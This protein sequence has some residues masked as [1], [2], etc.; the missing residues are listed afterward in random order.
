MPA[1]ALQSEVVSKH[2]PEVVTLTPSPDMELSL[3]SDESEG[4]ESRPT[5]HP[6]GEC[7][8]YVGAYINGYGARHI[9]GKQW[10]VH[11]WSYTLAYGPIPRGLVIDHLCRNRKCMRPSH[12]EAV[13]NHEN[14][15][16]GEGACAQNS[17]K[18]HCK[19]GHEF[20]PENT[21][22]RSRPEGGRRC[23]ECQRQACV[24]YNR[25]RGKRASRTI[26]ASSGE[27]ALISA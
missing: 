27:Q 9:Q 11:R 17:R 8:E 20:T 16:R 24:R 1:E 15:L 10:R 3:P 23:R 2:S 6:G 5:R 18:T 7:I 25:K 12:L 19:K 13:S 21:I 22:L 14:I 26:E 4:A